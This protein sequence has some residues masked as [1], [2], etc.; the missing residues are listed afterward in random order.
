M[1]KQPDGSDLLSEPVPKKH[2][3][4]FYLDLETTGKLFWKNGIHQIAGAIEIDG[5][6]VKRFNFKV[7]PMVGVKI[8]IEALCVCGVTWE[9]LNAYTTPNI[10]F[11]QIIQ[12]LETYVNKFDPT[13]KFFICAYNGAAFDKPFFRAFFVQNGNEYFETYFHA[14]CIDVFCLAANRI[15]EN[16]TYTPKFTQKAV[17]EYFHID[18]DKTKLHDG[19]YDVGLAYQLYQI[20]RK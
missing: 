1:I 16:G 11:A 8:D 15:A 3:K 13:D 10:V 7:R 19:N 12:M 14:P 6:V 4:I 17:C 5:E 2:P 20:L 9:E 18:L